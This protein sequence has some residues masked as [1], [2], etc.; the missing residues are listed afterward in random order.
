MAAASATEAT[1]TPNTESATSQSSP[2]PPPNE[3][4]VQEKSRVGRF[5]RLL[6]L[7]TGILY[8]GG[9]WLSLKNDNFN[10][11]FTEHVPLAERIVGFFEEREYKS[12]FPDS[13]NTIGAPW[14]GTTVKVPSQDGVSWNVA[15]DKNSKKSEETANVGSE[16]QKVETPGSNDEGK[17]VPE[18]KNVVEMTH[19]EDSLGELKKLAEAQSPELQRMVESFDAL[20]STLVDDSRYSGQIEHIKT[21]LHDV[22]HKV[23]SVKSEAKA[24][25]EKEIQKLHDTFDDS[26]RELMRQVNEVRE[27]DAAHFREEFEIE[28]ERLATTYEKQVAT[29]VGRVHEVAEQTLRNEL[30]EQAI[31]L[32][33]KFM[34]D[35][36][37]LVENEREGRLSKISHL[38]ANVA[39]LEQLT[40]EWSKVVEANHKAQELRVAIDAVRTAALDYSGNEV[41]RPFVRELASVQKLAG[42]NSVV[43]AAIASI[44]PESY[45]HGI[46]SS[47]QIIDRFR[48]VANEVRKASLLPEN[49]GLTSHFAS[50]LLSKVMFRNVPNDPT[51]IGQ[52]VESV[53]TRTASLLEEGN[54]DEAAR[55]VTSLSGW[56]K[57]LSQDWLADLRRVLEVRQAINVS[58]P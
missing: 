33:R 37:T 50:I 10:D 11:V 46:P 57:V 36:H 56:A 27:D 42:E 55:E 31:E 16:K 21:S 30:M 47:T 44:S 20:V 6:L 54:L 52:D 15:E 3:P 58:C 12:R 23:E 25:A 48:R 26:A 53:L 13:S 24:A 19:I 14:S 17:Q 32:N 22:M 45:Q 7:S 38:T 51:R 18:V 29:Q 28:R 34:Q 1:Q 35:I 39:E 49:A 9:V 40:A 2:S 8:G 5:F 41:P 43:S 4:P